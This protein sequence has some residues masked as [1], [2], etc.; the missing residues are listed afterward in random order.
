MKKKI[1][2]A[3]RERLRQSRIEVNLKQLNCQYCQRNISALNLAKHETSCKLNPDSKG[4]SYVD[5]CFSFHQR[6]CVVCKEF[7]CIEVHHLDSDRKNNSPTNLVPLC[8][9]HHR[10]WHNPKYK[11]IIEQTVL[12]YVRRFTQKYR[13]LTVVNKCGKTR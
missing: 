9:T 13:E 6:K 8:P 3:H 2:E 7:R 4:S 1:S 12:N 5:I 10:F 11:S